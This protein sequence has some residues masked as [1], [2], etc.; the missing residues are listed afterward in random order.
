[1]FSEFHAHTQK[2]KKILCGKKTNMNMHFQFRIKR[3]MARTDSEIHNSKQFQHKQ[4]RDKHP[5]D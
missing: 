2:K 5:E 4:I 1:M 3:Y